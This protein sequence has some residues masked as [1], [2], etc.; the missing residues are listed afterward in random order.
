MYK[1]LPHI[2]LS[3]ALRHCSFFFFLNL[4]SPINLHFDEIL[5]N[6]FTSKNHKNLVI[7]SRIQRLAPPSSFS[8]PKRAMCANCAL[9]A[10]TNVFEHQLLI[11]LI[12]DRSWN[13]SFIEENLRSKQKSTSST[14]LS[15]KL[16]NNNSF[17]S[18]LNLFSSISKTNSILWNT[19]RCYTDIGW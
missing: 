1:S 8:A 2:Y 5:L 7:F 14:L 13:S 12:P 4:L 19:L 10:T 9:S 15:W 3:S 6:C 11:G 17:I 16:K 18:C